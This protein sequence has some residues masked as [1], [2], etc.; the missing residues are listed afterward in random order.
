MI[1]APS[2]YSGFVLPRL[3]RQAGDT[4]DSDSEMAVIRRD[5]FLTQLRS[6]PFHLVLFILLHLNEY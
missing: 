4:H 6:R 5:E 1:F 2:V 3:I